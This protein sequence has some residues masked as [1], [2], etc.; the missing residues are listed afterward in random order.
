VR[1]LITGVN[2]RPEATGIGP[3]TAGLAEHLARRGHDVVVGT[4]FPHYPHWT[5]QEPAVP[6]RRTERL[7]GVEVRRARCIL[8]RSRSA[9]WRIVYDT[10]FAV[11]T[12]LTG[13][14]TPRPDV[15]VC[16]SPP[17]QN[18]L[19]GAL[20][21]R[22]WRVPAVLLVKD[23]PLEAALSVG[24]LRRGVGY[25]VGEWLER[26]AYALA[27]RI[28]VINPRFQANLT[29]QRVSLEK[30]VVIPDWVDLEEILPRSPEPEVRAMLGSA[31]GEFVVVHAGSMGEK[32]GLGTAV[33][34]ARIAARELPVQLALVGDGP[35]RRALEAMVRERGIGNVRLLPVQA[36]STFPRVLA[37]A[38]ALLLHQRAD[39]LDSVAPSKLLAYMAAGR[40]ILAAAHPQSVAAHL[41]T[42]A[43]CGV[44]VRPEAPDAL[45]EAMGALSRDPERRCALGLAGR[46]FV[47]EHFDKRAILSRW[48]EVLADTAAG[49]TAR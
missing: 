15:V 16:V 39:V 6:W 26:W 1:L 9:A 49:G 34:A 4:T 37:A 35:Q 47:E 5:W 30:V 18:A 21:A 28:V 22:R 43:G 11:S 31:N 40:P 20:L 8:P 41:V 33:D 12:L 3:Y 17:I 42:E 32:Q 7:E 38:D 23:L 13:I 19:A 25:R 36:A 29:R 14:P 45:A 2:Y 24:M 46:R 10:S 27:G 44:I 48:E